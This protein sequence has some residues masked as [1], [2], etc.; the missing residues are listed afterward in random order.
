MK[1]ICAWCGRIIKEN[2]GE[3]GVS[4]SI[5]N[6]CL[7][8]LQIDTEGSERDIPETLFYPVLLLDAAGNVKGMNRKSRTLFHRDSADFR[9]CTMCRLFG[10]THASSRREGHEGSSC[11][12]CSLLS[13]VSSTWQTGISI[14]GRETALTA[15]SGEHPEDSIYRISTRKTDHYVLLMIETGE[16]E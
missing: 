14:R 2:D 9:G 11:Q 15:K 5:C 7:S 6:G 8:D 1:I 13:T 4:H 16:K 12:T 3:A 10:C